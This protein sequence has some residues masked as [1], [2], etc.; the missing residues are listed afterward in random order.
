MAT[1]G[2][3][4]L[5]AADSY[6]NRGAGP[7]PCT[8]TTPVKSAALIKDVWVTNKGDEKLLKD[9]VFTYN[10]AITVL[11]FTPSGLESFRN[12]TEGIF[13][14]CDGEDEE[15]EEEEE[16]DDDY[17][18]CQAVTVVGYDSENGTDY[19]LVKNSWGEEWGEEGYFRL[20]RGVGMCHVAESIGVVKCA[21]YA[22]G[23]RLVSLADCGTEEECND[24]EWVGMKLEEDED[25][26][27]EA[28][29]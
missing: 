11:C 15:E 2:R 26:E 4:K 1:K 6:P 5:A 24:T 13:D 25:E 7:F 8:K 19:W 12:Y 20:A 10:A 9:L 3:T 18:D 29:Q 14:G 22:G 27:G 16:E 28:E 21:K 23:Q 17:T